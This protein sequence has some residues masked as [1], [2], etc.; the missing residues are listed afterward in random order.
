MYLGQA[1][2]MLKRLGPF[3]AL[4]LV[5]E[6]FRGIVPRL[7]NN[8]HYALAPHI[9]RLIFG[10]L[11]TKI[12]QDWLWHGHTS[13][14]DIL[15]YIPY[16]FFFV[17]PIGLALLVWKTRE[18][19]YWQVIN[20]Y[21]IV[22]FAAFLTFLL[23][24][25]APPWLAAQNHYIEPITRIS[26]SVWNTL[27][28]RDFPSVYNHIAANPVAAIPSLHAACATLLTIFVFKLYGRKWGFA[29]ASYPLLLYI[30]VVYE[31][32]H[33]VFDVLCGIAY[34]LAGYLVTPALMRLFRRLK[35][36]YR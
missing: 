4:I 20:T 33:Y 7:N 19:Y 12:M 13:W 15:L 26:S 28:I 1:R 36:L 2:E 32:E 11:P 14:Y 34:A 17:I 8:V 24:P 21:L 16:L 22:F 25:A 30:G 6:S 27:G 5:Y 9:D 3:V 10:G 23:Y 18:K 31:G 29:S 35:P